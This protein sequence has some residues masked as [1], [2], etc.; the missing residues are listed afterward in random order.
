[1]GLEDRVRE[2]MEDG[3]VK[4]PEAAD[5]LK[6]S[7]AQLYRLMER[8]ELIYTKIGKSRRI[9]RRALLDLAARGLVARIS[10]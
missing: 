10:D 5:F 4:I 1:M 2:M 8:G 9:P 6:I 7:I 3:L